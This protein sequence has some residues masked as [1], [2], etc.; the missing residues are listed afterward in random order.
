MSVVR[1]FNSDNRIQLKGGTRNFGH[2][3]PRYTE[4]SLIS[5]MDMSHDLAR[6]S[7]KRRS[8]KQHDEYVSSSLASKSSL[9]PSKALE[10]LKATRINAGQ[11]PCER[12][13]SKRHGSENCPWFKK[14]R[15][16]HPDARDAPR[17]GEPT[18]PVVILQRAKVVTMPGDGSCLFHSLAYGLGSKATPLRR[19]IVRFLAM[20]PTLEIAESPL[21]DWVQWDSNSSLKAYVRRMALSS[22]WGGA[23]E[24]FA[25]SRLKNVNVRIFEKLRNG[26]YKQIACFDVAKNFP[27]ID[28]LYCGRCHYNALVL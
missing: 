17:L 9:V 4:S 22:T 27:T 10:L 6:L 21:E 12:C 18:G 13:D 16:D 2:H 15:D 5:N 14:D 26:S 7:L 28:V 19:D 20:N 1:K 8:I 3:E 25:C 23:I 11:I 24:C